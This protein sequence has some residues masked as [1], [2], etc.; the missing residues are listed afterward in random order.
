M[1]SVSHTLSV[2]MNKGS[3]QETDIYAAAIHVNFRIHTEPI[4]LIFLMQ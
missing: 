1:S 3:T 2:L 4:L